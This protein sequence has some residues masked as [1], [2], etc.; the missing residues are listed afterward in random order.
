MPVSNG[1]TPCAWT[2]LLL[3]AGF[4]KLVF[5]WDFLSHSYI[6]VLLLSCLVFLHS[7]IFT[8]EFH[9][10]GCSVLFSSRDLHCGTSPSPSSLMDSVQNAMYFWTPLSLFP[11]VLQTEKKAQHES[12]ELSFTGGKMRTIALETGFQ[13]ALRN[14]AKEIAG[15]SVC[16]WFE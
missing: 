3:C 1:E 5:L 7:W 16:T 4:L 10:W 2:G 8:S 11:S 12:W 13:V 14:C 9:S 6:Y 15:E